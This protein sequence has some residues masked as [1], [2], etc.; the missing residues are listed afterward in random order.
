VPGMEK[1][2]ERYVV[3]GALLVVAAMERFRLNGVTVS[4]AGLLEGILDEVGRN[5]GESA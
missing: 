5:G 4:D 2:R 3:P 1:G